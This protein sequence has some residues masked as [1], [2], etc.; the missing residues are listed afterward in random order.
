MGRAAYRSR[1]PMMATFF[2]SRT[3]FASCWIQSMADWPEER[4]V[5]TFLGKEASRRFGP[6]LSHYHLALWRTHHERRCH[7][8]RITVASGDPHRARCAAF[9]YAIRHLSHAQLRGIFQ[10]AKGDKL[11]DR[12]IGGKIIEES[13]LYIQMLAEREGFEPS[14]RLR[15]HRFSRPAYSTTLAPLQ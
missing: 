15:A 5:S 3:E 10:T 9:V 7:A 6:D 12:K 1:R 8:T 14:E 4:R 2:P 11:G 13:Q